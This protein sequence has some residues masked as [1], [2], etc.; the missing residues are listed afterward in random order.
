RRCLL[1]AAVSRLRRCRS[2]PPPLRRLSP[3]Y[4]W[5]SHSLLAR[6]PDVPYRC[7]FPVQ[8]LPKRKNSS[9]RRPTRLRLYRSTVLRSHTICCAELQS[10]MAYGRSLR[11]RSPR[12]PWQAEAELSQCLRLPTAA[13]SPRTHS[14]HSDP[15][16]DPAAASL[17]RYCRWPR[18]TSAEW[19][20]DCREYLQ[21]SKLRE[22]GR[23]RDRHSE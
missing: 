8:R 11:L 7:H 20:R 17:L 3:F 15:R 12:R 19:H 14:W 21:N 9:C 10:S 1:Q 13:R 6:V 23:P 16:R 22:F 18:H 4:P 2:L 5:L